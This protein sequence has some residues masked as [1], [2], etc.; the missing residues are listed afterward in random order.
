MTTILF[1][2]VYKINEA[3]GLRFEISPGAGVGNHASDVLHMDGGGVYTAIPDHPVVLEVR[4]LNGNEIELVISRNDYVGDVPVSD[5]GGDGEVVV[6]PE[7]VSD[8][9][10]VNVDDVEPEIYTRRTPKKKR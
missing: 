8:V 1:D 3:G 4:F 7:P 10:D 6:E 9:G 5:E 2:Q